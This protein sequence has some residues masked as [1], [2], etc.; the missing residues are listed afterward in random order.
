M[1][2]QPHVHGA[3]TRTTI[4]LLLPPVASAVNQ[5]NIQL[6]QKGSFNRK[7]NSGLATVQLVSAA[8]AERCCELLDG[9]VLHTG[10]DPAGGRPMIVR[11]NK[12]VE[13]QLNY[14]GQHPEQPGSSSDADS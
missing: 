2:H 6:L 14:D 4:G 12:F 3:V 5:A 11:R 9:K 10:A 8:D 1:L 7:H 13:S